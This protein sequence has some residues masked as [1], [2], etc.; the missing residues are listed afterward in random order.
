MVK[1]FYKN[2]IPNL[3]NILLSAEMDGNEEGES[4]PKDFKIIKARWKGAGTKVVGY[5]DVLIWD[6]FNLAKKG[7]KDVHYIEIKDEGNGGEEIAV[8]ELT[9][10]NLWEYALTFKYENRPINFTI[11]ALIL[12]Y[13]KQSLGRAEDGEEEEEEEE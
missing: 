1:T 13:R 10:G 8:K 6:I 11:P 12:S 4:D 3:E 2:I 5:F 7:D 9:W